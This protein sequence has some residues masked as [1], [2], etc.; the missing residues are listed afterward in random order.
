[1]WSKSK[2]VLLSCVLVKFL[3]PI[4]VIG[5][6][7]IPKL[8]YWYTYQ[9]RGDDFF[10]PLMVA[11]Y[12]LLAFAVIAVYCLD[13]LLANIKN[14]KVFISKNVAFLRTISWC[15]FGVSIVFAL[16]G[17]Y[18]YLALSL[19]FATAFLGIILRVVKNVI[20]QAVFIREENEYTI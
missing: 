8:A 11:L 5:A 7:I 16:L 18:R 1:M 13:R 19:C 20:E 2:S 10:V 15:C 9:L 6:F 12:V 3:F 14:E 4:L 17:F